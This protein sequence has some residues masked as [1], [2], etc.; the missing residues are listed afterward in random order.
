MQQFLKR[1]GNVFF[2]TLKRIFSTHVC[3]AKCKQIT[4]MQQ[5]YADKKPV[6]IISI[7]VVCRLYQLKFY[8]HQNA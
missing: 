7:C 2:L 8:A 3:Y 5:I 6:I 4:L 1:K